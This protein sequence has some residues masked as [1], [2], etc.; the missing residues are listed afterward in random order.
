MKRGLWTVVTQ[1]ASWASWASWAG[2]AGES[3]LWIYYIYYIVG[4]VEGCMHAGPVTTAA[5]F[6]RGTRAR[7]C[8]SE[9]P[10]NASRPQRHSA[11]MVA[12]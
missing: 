2:G 6:W 7:R 1:R 12:V 8:S 11:Q 9:G 10:S 5:W 3:G 4:T